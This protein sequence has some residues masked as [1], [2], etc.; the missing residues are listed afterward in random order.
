MSIGPVI[1]LASG[2]IQ[3]LFTRSV[4]GSSSTSNASASAVGNTK[5]ANQFSS[6]AQILSS[7]QQL[8]QSNPSHY[9]QV[10]QQIASNLQTASQSATSA[11]NTALSSELTQLS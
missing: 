4:N 9:L 7:L 10:T 1:N 8:E 2:Y 5:E 6:F 3:S 11:G